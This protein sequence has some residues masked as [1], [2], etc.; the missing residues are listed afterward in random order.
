MNL[1]KFNDNTTAF[2][3]SNQFWIYLAATIPLT[4]LT[5][6]YWRYKTLQQRKQKQ[7]REAAGKT[8]IV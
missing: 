7:Q 5:L 6:G 1:F 3:I 8:D 4:I 2:D